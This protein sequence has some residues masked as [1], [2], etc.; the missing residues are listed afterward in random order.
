MATIEVILMWQ[1]GRISRTNVAIDETANISR[2]GA[3][4]VERE[5]EPTGTINDEG[6]ELYREVIAGDLE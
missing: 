4:G 2:V 1:D 5:F 6:V 3:D